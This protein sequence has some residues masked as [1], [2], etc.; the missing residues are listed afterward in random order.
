MTHKTLPEGVLLSPEDH[1][2][3]DEWAV[4]IRSNGYTWA[5]RGHSEMTSL[6]LLVL[7]RWLGPRPSD[8]VGDHLDRNRLDNR[9]ENLR[10]AT[11]IESI[12]NRKGPRTRSHS[13]FVGVYR[14]R[15]AGNWAG[16]VRHRGVLYQ[17]GHFDT[18][19]EAARARDELA[20]R[21]QGPGARLNF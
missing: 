9:R 14:K 18:A 4:G 11:F 6:H 15:K 3:L 21:V 8:H 20:L 19:E 1:C 5:S 7:T 16:Q 13:G 12:E 17:A 2:L 10:W